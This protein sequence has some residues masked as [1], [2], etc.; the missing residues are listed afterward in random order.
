MRDMPASEYSL[1]RRIE[2]ADTDMG[3]IVHFSRFFVF[4]ETTEHEFLRSLGLRVHSE[5][6]G[7]T[8][9]WPRRE[10]SCEYLSPARLGDELEICLRVRRKGRTSLGYEFEIRAGQR[11]VA[12]GKL[13]AVC[14][15]LGANGLKPMPLPPDLA[16]RIGESTTVVAR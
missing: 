7:V 9:A 2:F 8:V 1:R 15:V 13:S 11:L 16:A 14:C 6:Q 5:H 3:G 12:I 4:M 10:A